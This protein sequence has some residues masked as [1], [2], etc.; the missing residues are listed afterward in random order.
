MAGGPPVVLVG[1][2]FTPPEARAFL[3]DQLKRAQAWLDRHFFKE[4]EATANQSGSPALGAVVATGGQ[5]GT[6]TFL[7]PP[8]LYLE[9]SS[10]PIPT[11]SHTASTLK[12][13]AVAGGDTLSTQGD[14][15]LLN[16]GKCSGFVGTVLATTAAAGEGLESLAARRV[17]GMGAPDPEVWS[18]LNP[19]GEVP[20]PFGS[21]NDPVLPVRPVGPAMGAAGALRKTPAA[22]GPRGLVGA[23]FERWLADQPG[24][25]GSFTVGGREFDGAF[26][27]RW[28][29]AKSGRY[30][31][32]HANPGPGFEKF[33]SGIGARRRI[34]QQHGK[35]YEVHSN[36][37]VP[38]HVKA[39]LEEKGITFVEHLE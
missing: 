6:G 7:G 27:D 38:G 28:F 37:P 36:V 14:A 39:W 2:A 26:G 31:E 23:E 17:R 25:T 15:R 33:K 20:N 5:F 32:D 16:V 8:I 1:P 18:P 24:A 34:A 10:R 30:W 3:A 29:E 9:L 22:G 19:A 13:G 21:F 12:V 11:I 35:S 4:G